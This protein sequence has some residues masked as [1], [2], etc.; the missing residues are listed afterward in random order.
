MRRA[1]VVVPRVLLRV[2][3]IDVDQLD[4]EVAVGA[5][6]G[7]EELGGDLAGDDD[8]VIERRAH[9][10]QHVGAMIDEAL[11]GDFPVRQSPSG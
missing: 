5:G 11:V 6:G 7:G 1:G 3:R 10:G 8:V 2:L 9:I 4:D